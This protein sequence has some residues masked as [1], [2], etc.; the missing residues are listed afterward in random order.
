MK[1]FSSRKG[2]FILIGL[3]LIIAGFLLIGRGAEKFYIYF[4]SANWPVV[5]AELV[6]AELVRS[7]RDSRG[8]STTGIRGKFL[9]EYNG[10]QYTGTNIDITGGSNTDHEGKKMRLAELLEKKARGEQLDVYVNP[11]DPT[12]SFI[13]R[14]ISFDMFGYFLVGMIAVLLGYFFCKFSRFYP[15]GKKK[16]VNKASVPDSYSKAED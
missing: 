3:P 11:A 7:Q 2:F 13:Y 1:L 6:E 5:K 16:P 10:K 14:D 9:Y 8:G 4:A 15:F 12:F